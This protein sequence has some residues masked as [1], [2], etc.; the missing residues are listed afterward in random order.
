MKDGS[1]YVRELWLQPALCVVVSKD[2]QLQKGG[3]D[4]NSSQAFLIFLN[5]NQ[6]ANRVWLGACGF[7]DLVCLFVCFLIRISVADL[8]SAFLVTPGPLVG[9]RLSTGKFRNMTV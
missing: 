5:I 8:H 4:I 2:R 6:K 9:C 3:S 1:L 7:L